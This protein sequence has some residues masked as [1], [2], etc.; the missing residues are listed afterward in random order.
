MEIPRAGPVACLFSHLTRRGRT[1]LAAVP[2]RST[3]TDRQSGPV[4]TTPTTTRTTTATEPAGMARTARKKHRQL[5]RTQQMPQTQGHWQQQQY[6]MS[7]SEIVSRE[8][9]NGMTRRPRPCRPGQEQRRHNNGNA[10]GDD[11]SSSNSTSREAAPPESVKRLCSCGSALMSVVAS[12][13]SVVVAAL[14]PRTRRSRLISRT[15]ACLP[16][17]SGPAFL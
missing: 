13:L 17:P 12:R 9:T 15:W 11:D 5:R 7:Q 3:Q 1:G 8:T 16:H 4:A 10:R 6:Y 2:V 14:A